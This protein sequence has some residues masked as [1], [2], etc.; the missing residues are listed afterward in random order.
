[1][2][3]RQQRRLTKEQQNWLQQDGRARRDAVHSLFSTAD[4]RTFLYWLLQ[5]T[6]AMGRSP[7]TGNAL[8][9]SFECGQHN[10][11]LQ[12][13]HEMLDIAPDQFFLMLKEK[14]DE[15]T[16]RD[17]ATSAHADTRPEFHYDT[18]PDTYTSADSDTG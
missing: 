13:M 15:R 1:M 18:N 5:I 9:T 3:D 7:F 11:G 16:Y 14:A 4:G 12:V 6:N 2:D 8:T 10:I 17:G